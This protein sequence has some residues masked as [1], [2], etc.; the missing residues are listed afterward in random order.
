LIGDGFPDAARLQLGD[1]KRLELDSGDDDGFGDGVCVAMVELPAVL[2][3]VIVTER[4]AGTDSVTMADLS[5]V[6]DGVT[7]TDLDAVTDAV[8]VAE[9]LAVMDGVTTGVADRVATA[10]LEAVMETEGYTPGM[11]DV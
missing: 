10:E 9:L 7:S 4:V 6:T 5:A 3:G 8:A 11:H 2:D 1:R